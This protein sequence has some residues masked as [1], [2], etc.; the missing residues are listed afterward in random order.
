M[1]KDYLEAGK[2]ANTH[3]IDG[4]VVID[5]WCNSLEDFL[6]LKR[7]FLYEN[8]KYTELKITS[9]AHK[10]RALCRIEGIDNIDKAILLKNKT[11][12]AKREDIALDENDHF[13]A[14]LIGLPVIDEGSG[15]VYGKLKDVIQ[16]GAAD[17]YVIAT[18]GEDRLIPA[19]KEFV[20]RIQPDGIFVT[21]IPG[22]FDDDF[23]K[24]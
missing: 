8:G 4:R 11:V 17:V 15:K 3:G 22:M 10:G 16:N 21:P 14:D 23:E 9:G 13:V 18:E 20:K 1:K 6:A 24:A 7:I 19:V 12:Y 2:I 5:H